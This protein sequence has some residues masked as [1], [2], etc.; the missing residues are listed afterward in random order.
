MQGHGGAKMCDQKHTEQHYFDDAQ[1]IDAAEKHN[2]ARIGIICR[3]VKNRLL[4]QERTD[5]ET[6]EPCRSLTRW[7][8]LACPWSYATANRAMRDIEDLKDIPDEHLAE[9][10]TSNFPI[11]RQLST[12]VRSEPAMLE[13]AKTRQSEDFVDQVREAHPEQHLENRQT[14][15]FK[16]VES[17]AAKIEEAIAK[18]L[19]KGAATR[20]E[21]LEMIAVT[22]LEDW[23]YEEELEYALQNAQGWENLIDSEPRE[24]NFWPYT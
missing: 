11:L 9:I 8:K 16:P 10:P 14:L 3:E 18:A 1:N 15:R 24:R 13:A 4:W 7:I 23:Q 19:S 22:A 21:A 5:P 2:Y 12:K 6:S 20:D 17:A